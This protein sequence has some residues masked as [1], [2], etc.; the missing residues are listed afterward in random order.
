MKQSEVK[1][2]NNL[3]G[4]GQDSGD[5]PKISWTMGGVCQDLQVIVLC[6]AMASVFSVSR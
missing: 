1:R 4:I 2:F 6:M 3:L 5:F